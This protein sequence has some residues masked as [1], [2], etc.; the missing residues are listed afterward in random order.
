MRMH[1]ILRQE[2]IMPS[3]GILK[4]QTNV[5]ETIALHY[6][7]GRLTQSQFGGDQVMFTLM[8]GRRLYLSPFVANRIKD[9]GVTA[10][11]PFSICKR[12]VLHGNRRTIDYEV[13]NLEG[14]GA[15]ASDQDAPAVAVTQGS[16]RINH[17]FHG[18]GLWNGATNGNAPANGNGNGA[19]AAAATGPAP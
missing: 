1:V 2:K 7:D 4:L 17:P 16:D 12:E 3:D 6:S 13:K 19:T 14:R 10:G 11:V 9:A 18:K 8:D 5:P 15:G